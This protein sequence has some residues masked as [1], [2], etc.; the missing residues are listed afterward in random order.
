MVVEDRVTERNGT[1]PRLLATKAG[2]IALR[3]RKLRKGSFFPSIRAA[4]SDRVSVVRGRDGGRRPRRLV[5]RS[6]GDL[7]LVLGA[8]SGIFKS[9]A[10]R[11]CEQLDEAV[12]A[13]RTRAL[14]HAPFPYVYL[15]ATYMHVRDKP[16]KGADRS[17]RWRLF[18]FERD[19]PLIVGSRPCAS[20][21][22][23]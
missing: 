11:I 18:N 1:R 12:G 16:G 13:F 7:V 23:V 10:S 5:T 19:G 20:T 2:Y 21:D 15:D 22:V 8:D 9:G 14:D 3:I 6:V 4:A 17:A